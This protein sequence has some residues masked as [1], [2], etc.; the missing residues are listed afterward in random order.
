[1]AESIMSIEAASKRFGNLLANDGI[2]I[3]FEAGRLHAI[4]GENGAGKSTLINLLAGVMRP[5]SGRILLDGQEVQFKTSQE[6][7]ARGVSVVFQRSALV[8]AMTVLENVALR[9]VPRGRVRWKDLRERVQ[10]TCRELGFDVPLGRPVA[11]LSAGTRQRAEIVRALVSGAK[12]LVLDEPTSVLT[13][14]ERTKLFRAL[15]GL[16][17]RGDCAIVF[18][19]HRIDEVVQHADEVTILR[20]GQVVQRIAVGEPLREPD[21]VAAMIGDEIPRTARLRAPSESVDDLAEVLNVSGT[22][23]ETGQSLQ[24]VAFSVRS[25]EVLGIAGIEGSGQVELTSA[26]VGAWRPAIGEVRLLGRP[27]SEYARR[28]SLGLIGDIPEAIEQA[29]VP[30]LTVWRNIALPEFLWYQRPTKRNRRKALSKASDIATQFDVRG[31]DP[32]TV[33]ANLSGG[34][35]QRLVLGR[36]LSRGPRLLVACHPTKGLDVRSAADVRRRLMDAAEGGAAVVVVSSD[37]DELFDVSDRIMVMVTGRVVSIS[38][39]RDT[40]RQEVGATLTS[41]AD[42]I[43]EVEANQ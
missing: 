41:A 14:G 38:R 7:I 1:M 37:L 13:P 11:S 18:V 9:E 21:L 2:S 19:T 36:E 33:C 34:N 8:P 17:T 30:G 26:L 16:R 24:D 28:E 5:D 3:R 6:A 39:T 15:A 25:G 40:N 12:V 4:L 35:Q 29:V 31:G 42:R 22:H 20:R 23:P 10:E 43:A 27:L 32:N